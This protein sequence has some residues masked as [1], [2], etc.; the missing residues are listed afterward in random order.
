[1][2]V[3]RWTVGVAVM[4][5]GAGCTA[6]DGGDAPI[7]YPRDP[8]PVVEPPPPPAFVAMEQ[9]FVDAGME[10]EMDRRWEDA[11]RHYAPALD[12][13]ADVTP[14]L[15][16]QA[17][18]RTAACLQALRR[19]DAAA[20]HLRAVLRERAIAPDE[21]YPAPFGGLR[22]P[23]RVDAEKRLRECGGDPVAVYEAMLATDAAEV[24]VVCLARLADMR[25]KG[26]IERVAADAE[27]PE[28]L[29]G[30]AAHELET[31]GQRLRK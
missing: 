21:D 23:M 19:A 1:M 9:D 12:D 28:A 20:P 16:A 30:L 14:R 11:L 31:W 4:L 13:R 5:A 10:L 7:R 18:L 25:S 29:R 24:A 27:R 26:L 8:E 3:M 2:P 6:G 22:S 17:R 15:R